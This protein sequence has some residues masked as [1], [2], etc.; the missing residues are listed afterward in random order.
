MYFKRL[1][2]GSL[3]QASPNS[4][5]ILRVSRR[6]FFV[7]FCISF[8]SN[9]GN[10][11]LRLALVVFDKSFILIKEL[12]IAHLESIKIAL[13]G[14]NPAMNKKNC[15]IFGIKTTFVAFKD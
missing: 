7:R 11:S 1:F 4:L 5:A 10:A 8:S 3:D 2:P 12:N 13:I 14:T 9:S 6:L 15:I